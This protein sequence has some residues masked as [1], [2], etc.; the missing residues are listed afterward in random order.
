MGAWRG[1]TINGYLVHG[2]EQTHLENFRCSEDS[3]KAMVAL[4]QGSAVEQIE[5]VRSASTDW[6]KTRRIIKARRVLDQP[7]GSFK[8]G[9]CLYAMAHGGP[10]KP[11]I[12]LKII[13]H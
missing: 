9:C 7:S 1:S 11:Y 10:L 6:R 5:V 12:L 13:Y 3:L 2:D 4:P 8:V